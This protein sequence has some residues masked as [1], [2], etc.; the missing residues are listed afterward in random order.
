MALVP[1]LSSP[2]LFWISLLSCFAIVLALL[3][4]SLAFPKILIRVEKEREFKNRFLLFNLKVFSVETLQY[5]GESFSLNLWPP[6]NFYNSTA[7]CLDWLQQARASRQEKTLH[8]EAFR[9][10]KI[11]GMHLMV[12]AG[13]C[14]QFLAVFRC[15]SCFI[16]EIPE[17]GERSFSQFFAGFRSFFVFAVFRLFEPLSTYH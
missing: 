5:R 6:S 8:N 7:G 9:A 17:F 4:I 15:F 2:V 12:H 3:C 10:E 13:N 16:W 1:W 11:N 14:R